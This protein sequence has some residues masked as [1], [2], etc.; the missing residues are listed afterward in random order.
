LSTLIERHAAASGRWIYAPE[1]PLV[2]ALGLGWA[3]TAQWL[4][5]PWLILAVRQRAPLADAER[6]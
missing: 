4:L 6:P 5:L 1:M 2:P 3:P